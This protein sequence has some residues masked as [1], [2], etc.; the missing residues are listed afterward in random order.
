MK[1]FVTG[2]GGFIGYHLCSFLLKNHH[3]VTIFDNNI[4]QN[5]KNILF[6]KKLGANIISGDITNVDLLQKSLVSHELIIHLAAKIDVNESVLHPEETYRVNVLGT[7]NI[8]DVARSLKITK[9]IA[10][11]SAAVYGEP[12]IIPVSE[13]HS[14][15]PLSPYGQS[16]L[17]MENLMKTFS[18]NYGFH[19]ICLRFFNVF[20]LGQTNAYAGVIT[21]FFEKISKNESLEIFGDGNNTR[22]F[23]FV[24]D[25]AT[26]IQKSISNIEN[27]SFEIFNV[28][29]G[30]ATTINELAQEILKLSNS[31][32]NVVFKSNRLGDIKHSCAD[33]SK[34][35]KIL[36]FNP[37]ISL[38]H[39]LEV[40]L[41]GYDL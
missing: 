7:K 4:D 13:D 41:K 30:T 10:A 26:A 3:Q 37:S 18:E 28:G 9:I 36:D 38:K 5:S 25:V 27:T 12:N 40:F 15:L 32:N 39:G 35:Q 31:N 34:I 19:C 24:N 16:K 33:I 21:K 14:T 8:L 2:G 23:I 11:S 6:L 1:I 20:G 22:D 29:T 17:D